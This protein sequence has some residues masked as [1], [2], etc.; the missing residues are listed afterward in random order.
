MNAYLVLG[1][2]S[3]GTRL[4]TRILMKAGCLGSDQ[5]AQIW[6][7]DPFPSPSQPIVFRRSI[8]HNK[9]WPDIPRIVQSLR[10]KGYT[11]Q[12]VVTARD[13]HATS[14]SQAKLHVKNQSEAY[15]NLG[16]VYPY[17]FDAL[18]KENV[19]YILVTYESI[20]HNTSSIN[21]LLEYLQLP[22]LE[23]KKLNELNIQNGN[24][25]WYA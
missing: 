11:V 24:E 20:I 18:A 14:K 23:K 12:A 19:P 16:K 4:T 13:W 3:T 6:D 1:P 10:E 21:T 15:A 7:N 25:K 5:H 2:E 17:I 22:T 8:P 9:T